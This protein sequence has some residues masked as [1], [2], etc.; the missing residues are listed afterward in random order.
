VDWS[1]T[2]AVSG[3]PATEGIFVNLK[4]REPRGIVEP[5]APYEDLREKL[6]AELMALRDPETKE[7]VVRSVYRREDLYEGPYLDQLPDVVFD[8]GD[9]P[10]LASDALPSPSSWRKRG[11]GEATI[12]ALPREVLQGRHRS[13][14]IFVAAGPD[15]QRSGDG[16]I[17]GVR[18]VDVAPTVLYSLGLPIPED[19]DGR[20][21]LEVFSDEYQ[22]AHPVRYAEPVST[23]EPEHEPESGPEYDDEDAAEMERRLRGLGYVG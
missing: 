5:G 2:Q 15:I 19:M 14:G 6:M 4:G 1:R 16:Q 22:A 13:S 8:L 12:E 17:E 7:P 10:Y 23:G 18:I 3:S 20:P 9:G 21:L 11:D